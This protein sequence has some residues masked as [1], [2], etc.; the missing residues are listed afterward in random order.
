MP[1]RQPLAG[2]LFASI[3]SV[4]FGLTPAP[5]AAAPAPD[6]IRSRVVPV[7]SVQALRDAI[8]TAQAGDEIVIAA[9]TYAV[10]GNLT[11]SVAGTAVAPIVV[12]AAQPRSVLI[13]FSNPGSVAEGFKLQ[14][15]WWRI[16][17]LDIE[18]ACIDDSDCEHAFHITGDAD[19]VV[20]RN[21]RVRDFNAQIKSNGSPSGSVYVF[22]DDVLIEGN[23]FYDTRARNTGNPV[24]KID[25]VGGRRWIVRANTIFDFEKGGGNTISYAAFLK[26]HSYDGVFE[27]NLVRCAWHTS[28]GIRLGLSLG[29]G[30]TSPDPI[31]E[32]G[33][34][35]PEHQNGILRNNLI[36]GCSDVG[37]YLNKAADS[38]IHHNTLYATSGIDVRYTASSADL[39]NNLL[40]GAIRDRD[41]GSSTRSGNLAGITPT[42]FALWFVDPANAD[43]DL[44]D[45][46]ALVDQGVAAPLVT[47]DFCATPRSDGLPDIG[48][49]EYTP[50]PAC[51]LDQGGGTPRDRIFADGFQ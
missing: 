3:M 2:L 41:G 33:S 49:L 27:R 20:I 6:A 28:G 30:G 29:G 40:G 23:W 17:G 45:G 32:D 7:A 39:R 26:G 37:I 4:G 36:M 11:A 38:Q 51:T 48:A 31:C 18:G 50:Q 1:I 47:D 46:S 25:V 16:E 44:L 14:R 19:H 12:R 5:A 13:R 24:T 8:A 15:A 10:D 35:T 43:F 34:C 21:N 22:P 9:G 42:Q